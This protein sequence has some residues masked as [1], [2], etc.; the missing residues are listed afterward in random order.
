MIVCA[1]VSYL[2]YLF[3]FNHVWLRN[4]LKEKSNI[5]LLDGGWWCWAIPA[6]VLPIGQ[7]NPVVAGRATIIGPTFAVHNVYDP[8]LRVAT[9][10]LKEI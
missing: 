5:P 10:K 9:N 4:C 6:T 1:H 8:C 3:F 2:P 7:C